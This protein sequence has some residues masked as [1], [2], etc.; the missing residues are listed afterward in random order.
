MCLKSFIFTFLIGV[1]FFASCK[2][3]NEIN[4]PGNT[5]PT[6]NTITTVTKEDYIT[7]VYISVL[8]R[9]PNSLEFEKAKVIVNQNNISV[10]NRKQLLDTVFAHP[11]YYPRTY[12]I[13]LA[14]ILNSLD[15]AEIS[16]FIG[17]FNI[18]LADT[19][20][21]PFWDGV[22]KEKNRLLVM[23]KIPEDFKSGVIDMIGV[24]KRCVDNYLYDQ[25][26]MGTENFVV[27]LF[28]NFLFRYPTNSELSTSKTMVDGTG[29]AVFYETGKT[30]SDFI[31]IFFNSNDFFEGQ[32]KDLYKR[33]LFRDPT[34]SEMPINAVE[35]KKTLD[36]KA[37]QKNILSLDE[38]VGIK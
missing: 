10:A 17:V 15:T 38:Y 31:N 33:Y 24:Y 21:K 6:D 20:N 16:H 3:S 37:L 14:N 22:T 18:L 8:G 23:Q 4:I 1:L 7:K 25:I 32:V 26:N 11:D 35:F 27:S 5:P 12:Q 28:Q 29:A 34:S 30:K 36:Y 9:E 13:T 19:V 2:K